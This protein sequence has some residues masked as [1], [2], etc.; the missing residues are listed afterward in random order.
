M[1]FAV[2]GSGGLFVTMLGHILLNDC[3]SDLFVNSGIM[4]TSF[5]PVQRIV[6]ETC[7]E[8]SKLSSIKTEDTLRLQIIDESIE[9]Y[10]QI[11]LHGSKP[12]IEM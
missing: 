11:R 8:N 1:D 3:W 10:C 5:V 2:N 7:S 9:R 6:N 4:M 12:N